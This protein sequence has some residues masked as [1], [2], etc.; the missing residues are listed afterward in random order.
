ML[1][2]IGIGF[3][4]VLC[5]FALVV[6]TRPAAFHVERSTTIAAPPDLVFPLVNDFHAWTRWSPYEHRDPSMTREF[7]GA[8]A[9]EGAIYSW[10]GND[11]IGAGRM[12]LTRSVPN[13]R[14]AI[15]LEF[16]RPMTATNQVEFVFQ[17]SGNDTRVVWGMDGQHG[18]VG[19]L[20]SL[21]LDMDAMVGKD[22]EAG[23]AAMKAAAEADAKQGNARESSSSGRQR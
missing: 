22:F 18:I 19:K 9:G 4:V 17:G 20:I 14:V 12:T 3:V 15:R 10:E 5:V 1:K 21:F 11:D 16:S 7:A 2:K 8:S 13:E 6:A 23:L